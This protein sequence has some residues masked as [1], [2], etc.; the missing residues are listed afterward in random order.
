M[1][2]FLGPPGGPKNWTTHPEVLCFYIWLRGVDLFWGPPGG[3]KNRSTVATK[4]VTPRYR[5]GAARRPQKTD[6]FL[7]HVFVFSLTTFWFFADH[8]LTF[9]CQKLRATA[10]AGLPQMR[11]SG[12]RPAPSAAKQRQC[13]SDQNSTQRAPELESPPSRL[14]LARP[15]VPAPGRPKK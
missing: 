7:V 12:A 11:P 3:P 2:P 4:M 9:W 1:D 10:N 5:F 6:P 8:A 14:A 13:N 15:S